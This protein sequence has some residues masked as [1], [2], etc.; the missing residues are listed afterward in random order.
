MI[1]FVLALCLGVSGCL[2]AP[3][4]GD[5]FDEFGYSF[6]PQYQNGGCGA[7]LAGAQHPGCEFFDPCVPLTP[8]TRQCANPIVADCK[9]CCFGVPGTPEAKSI[10]VCSVD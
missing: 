3:D 1:R 6:E 8:F 10:T 5:L 9:S 4:T 7:N 2:Q